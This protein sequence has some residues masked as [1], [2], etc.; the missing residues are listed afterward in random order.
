MKEKRKLYEQTAKAGFTLIEVL[1]VVIIIG[2]L[3]AVAIP[4]FGGRVEQAQITRA[5]SDVQAIST[6]LRMFEVDNGKYPPNLQGLLSQP[7]G[8]INWRGPYLEQGL[9]KDPWNNDYVYT[10]PGSHNPH[11]YDLYSLGPDG[12]ASGDD[13]GNWQKTS[14]GTP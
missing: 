14:T 10:T 4:R 7:G 3:A 5:Q 1:L 9:P 2:I 13:I 8:A 12:S 6:A 11:S